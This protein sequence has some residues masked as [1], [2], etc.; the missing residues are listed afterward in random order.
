MI[1]KNYGEYFLICDICLNEDNKSFENFDDVVDYKKTEGK[2]LGWSSRKI[3]GEWKDICPECT[4]G[5]E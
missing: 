2:Q 1:D 5:G 4:K 3:N